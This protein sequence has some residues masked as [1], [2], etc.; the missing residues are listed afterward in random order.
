MTVYV[1]P[2]HAVLTL[3]FDLPADYVRLKRNSDWKFNS[4]AVNINRFGAAPNAG[5]FVA[6]LVSDGE[7]T[8][9]SRGTDT[10]RGGLC[11]QNSYRIPWQHAANINVAE[12]F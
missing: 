9:N 1:Q 11:F 6:S 7:R 2:K 10:C 12:V 4:H 5:V 3:P 8:K